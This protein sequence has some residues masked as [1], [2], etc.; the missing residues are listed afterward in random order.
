MWWTN[1]RATSFYSVGPG[2][3][4][5]AVMRIGSESSEAADPILTD[6]MTAIGVNGTP[7]PRTVIGDP[8]QACRQGRNREVF[9]YRVLPSVCRTEDDTLGHDA[10]AHEVPQ[11]DEQLARQGDDHLLAQAAVILGASFKPLGQGALL[12]ELEEAPRELDHSLPH[13]SIAGS[14]EPLLAALAPAFI[15]RAREPAV[16]CHGPAVA[17]VARDKISLTSMSAVSMPMPI[18]R[19]RTR[20]IRF[21]PVFG[22][23]FS[24]SRR[25]FS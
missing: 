2:P 25:A 4:H 7:P 15:G 9:F 1:N 24:C 14:R 13:P 20:S 11:G 17:Q 8:S 3:D 21:G 23:C 10:I 5:D 6:G 16:A 19:I 22:A 12:L 18:T